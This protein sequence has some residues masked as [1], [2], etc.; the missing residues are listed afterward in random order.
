MNKADLPFGMQTYNQ[1]DITL[2]LELSIDQQLQN[3]SVNRAEFI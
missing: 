2:D 1:G 3:Q